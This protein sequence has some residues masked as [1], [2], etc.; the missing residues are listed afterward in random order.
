M[1]RNRVTW[2]AY[3]MLA[4]I[5]I[6]QSILGPLMPFLRSEL[7]LNYTLGGLLPAAIAIGL[8]FSGLTG[9]WLT[10]RLGRRF[11]F[12]S[13]SIGLVLGVLMFARGR[14]FEAIFIAALGMGFASSLTQVIIQA[15]LSD[16]HG[17]HRAVALTEA[18]V[19]ASLSTTLT[20]LIIGGMPLL[21][22]DWRLIP[23]LP[24][25]ILVLLGIFFYRE[26]IPE[27]Q[28]IQTDAAS[29]KAPLPFSF[30]LYWMV[31]FLV[32]A[33][34]MAIVV[35][36][37]DFLANIAGLGRTNAALAFGAFPAA[38][39]IGRFLGSRITQRWPSQVLLPTALAVT[40]IG[41]PI[42][43]LA[44]SATFNVLGLFIAGLGIANL[45]PLTLS[46][47]VGVAA[48]Q[49]NQ[50][51]ARAS[52]AVGTALLGVPLLLGWLSDQIGIQIAYGIVIVLAVLAFVVV[53]NN[54]LL[55]KKSASLFVR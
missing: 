8:I 13:G 5:A 54:R 4:Y 23:L 9:D 36:A 16:Q 32:V 21:G 2:L 52:L 18:N 49:S 11:V 35:W 43:W 30:W 50:A 38:M 12:W 37:T 39:L 47:A 10:R 31:L 45:Y 53:I 24:F 41:F 33:V 48:D 3:L 40:M 26:P 1:H 29:G 6:S 27:S 46:I 7:S 55:L 28:T 44:R 42:F 20:P 14:T 25:L 15:L 17:E 34:E 19:A 22:L 51:S